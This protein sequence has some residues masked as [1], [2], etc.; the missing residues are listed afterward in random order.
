MLDIWLSFPAERHEANLEL[1]EAQALVE[2]LA[3]TYAGSG[4]E[5]VL[6]V[7]V[8]AMRQH[9]AAIARYRAAF[10]RARGYGFP[11]PPPAG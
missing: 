4:S 1:A 5:L 6:G 8:D 11:D 3:D 9:S 10:V 2:S 7:L